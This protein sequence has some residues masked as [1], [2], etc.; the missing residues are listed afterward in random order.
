[1]SNI[2]DIDI[3]ELEFSSHMHFEIN[4]LSEKNRILW[5]SGR[6]KRFWVKHCTLFMELDDGTKI[7]EFIYTDTYE[8]TK[9]P[10]KTMV[11][12]NNGEKW[13]EYTKYNRVWSMECKLVN[14]DEEE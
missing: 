3:I 10:T 14:G 4:D 11:G 7:D 12:F 8:D 1:M 13:L 6:V 9:W 5:K 2:K